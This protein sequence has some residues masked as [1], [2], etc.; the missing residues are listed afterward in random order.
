MA[1]IYLSTAGIKVGYGVETTAGTKPTTFTEIPDLVSIG[2]INPEP[3]TIKVT[4]LAEAEW[5]QYID[6]LKDVGGAISMSA[7]LT[8]DFIEA[9]ESV[10]SAA[11]TAKASGK[12]TWFVVVIPGLEKSFAFCGNPATLGF[13]GAEVSSALQTSVYITPTKIEGFIT[14][15]TL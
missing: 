15:V 5:E 8:D 3:Q 1:N 11:K 12:A 9:W 7:N 2:S 10:V 4:P 6:G 13:E 14:K